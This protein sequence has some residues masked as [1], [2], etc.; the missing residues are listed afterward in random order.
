MNGITVGDDG[1]LYVGISAPC[2]SCTPTATYS[3]SI[4]SFLP[5]GTDLQVFARD[6]RAAI[7]L[8][9]S[10]APTTSSSR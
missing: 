9:S 10:P 6:I 4:V 5:D 7:G 2:N 8:S 1:R 3:A